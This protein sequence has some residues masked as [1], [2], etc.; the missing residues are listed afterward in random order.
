[1]AYFFFYSTI[2]C[3]K[4]TIF[5]YFYVQRKHAGG[6]LFQDSLRRKKKRKRERV[7]QLARP[8][9]TILASRARRRRPS[10]AKTPPKVVDFTSF[11]TVLIVET[12]DRIEN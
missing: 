7:E 11:F 5:H 6:V 3:I 9:T 12:I 10:V 1:M 2:D 8:A 4:G